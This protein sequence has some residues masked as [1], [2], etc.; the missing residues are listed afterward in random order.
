MVRIKYEKISDFFFF[1]VILKYPHHKLLQ[2]Q[3][4]VLDLPPAV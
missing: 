1:T 4:F 3:V 2:I